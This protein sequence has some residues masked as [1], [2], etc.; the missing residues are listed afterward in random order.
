MWYFC[1]MF[2]Y[3]T[4]I[5]RKKMVNRDSGQY[6]F[7]TADTQPTHS[8]DSFR[9]V[10]LRAN[11][12]QLQRIGLRYFYFH[13]FLKG[14]FANFFSCR[15]LLRLGLMTWQ[16]LNCWTWFR[17]LSN[18]VRWTTYTRCYVTQ[19]ILTTAVYRIATRRR[20]RPEWAHS[21]ILR[22]LL[23][24]TAPCAN[25]KS[26]LTFNRDQ[27]QPTYFLSALIF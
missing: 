13:F 12:T 15:C 11:S 16:T 2:P 9:K 23:H 1:G 10:T 24:E 26:Y 19:I 3:E 17:S 6:Y 4:W 7:A 22:G 20:P 5:T 14:N 21:P 18:S 25:P 8:V 27:Y